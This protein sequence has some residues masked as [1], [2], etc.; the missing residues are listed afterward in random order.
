MK[1][2]HKLIQDRISEVRKTTPSFEHYRDI[3][4]IEAAYIHG[5][6]IDVIS[7]TIFNSGRAFKFAIAQYIHLI[8][9]TLPN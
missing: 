8:I 9:K 5:I 7:A 6:I 2:V 4:H 3:N 1:D